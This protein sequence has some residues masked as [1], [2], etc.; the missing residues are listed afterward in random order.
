[1]VSPSAG[2]TDDET[3][4]DDFTEALGNPLATVFDDPYP[5]Y[6]IFARLP[7][8]VGQGRTRTDAMSQRGQKMT[9]AIVVPMVKDMAV[10]QTAIVREIGW[11]EGRSDARTPG[12]AL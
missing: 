5:T 9:I 4:F 3:W 11:L 12:T 1:M 7:V 2:V 8:E 6:D 10:I